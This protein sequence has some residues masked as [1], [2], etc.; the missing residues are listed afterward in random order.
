[1]PPPP[2][3]QTVAKITVTPGYMLLQPGGSA[4]L[5]ARAVDATGAVV[6]NAAITWSTSGNAVTVSADGT[7]SAGQSIDSAM[8]TA[9]VGSI[10]SAPVTVLVA[11]LNPGTQ[12]VDDSQVVSDPALLDANQPAGIGAQIKFTLAGST[13][14]AIGTLIVG[15]GAKPIDGKVISTAQNGANTDVVFQVMPL[16]DVFSELKLNQ[17]YAKDS[18]TQNFDVQPSQTIARTDGAREYEFILDT[19]DP[20]V[21]SAAAPAA[22]AKPRIKAAARPADALGSV[23]WSVGPFKCTAKS[24]LSAAISFKNMTP[25]VVDNLGPVSATI[26]VGQGVFSAQLSAKGS[27]T[28]SVDGEVHLSDAL[29]DSVSCDARLFEY[30]VPVPPVLAVVFIPVVPVIGLRANVSGTLTVGDVIIGVKSQVQQPLTVGMSIGTDGTFTNTSSLDGDATASFDWTLGSTN[31]TDVLRFSGDAK[32]GVFVQASFTSVLFALYKVFHP[33]FD[34]IKSLIDG[35]GGFH[36]TLGLAAVN[37]QLQDTTVA[38]GYAFTSLAQIQAGD[39]ISSFVSLL[40]SLLRLGNIV[41]PD[42]K[43]ETTL[44]SHPTG[45]ARVSLRRFAAGESV[46][47]RVVLDPTT[48]DPMFLGSPIIPYNVKQVQIWRKTAGGQ[49][50]MVGMDVGEAGA[51]GAPG[52]NVFNILW[53]ADAAGTTADTTS[54]TLPANFYAVVVPILG[55]DFSFRVGPALGWYGI[56]QIGGPHNGEGHRVAVDGDGN[57]IVATISGDPLASENRT[58]IG[59]AYEIEVFK[60]DPYGEL[61]WARNIDGPGDENVTGLAL[62]AQGNVF[63][64]GRAVNSPL[65]ANNIG[66]NGF[67]GWAASF[68]SSGNQLWLKQWQDGY[69]STGEFIALG[70]NREVYVL[71]TNSQAAGNVGGDVL[72]YLCNDGETPTGSGEDCGDLNLRR[73]DPNTGGLIWAISDARAGWQ[74]ARGLTVDAGG[75]IYTATGTGVD[76]ETQNTGDSSANGFER[77]RRWLSRAFGC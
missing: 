60:F 52:K 38:E 55:E 5:V 50:E 48:V 11:S 14:P 58:S 63:V 18:L 51:G 54:G 39:S 64:A 68:S 19:P 75:N 10:V 47:F 43:F 76:T 20:P 9:S 56:L 4:Q 30:F 27:I 33:D 42:L 16:A 12:V 32:A 67:S 13:A 29:K 65:T 7:I 34:P 28:L 22:R 62:D 44:F 6:S 25:H 46:A 77:L 2:P 36:G 49:S 73:L 61:I 71:G 15:S 40:S 26:N 45:N 1:M 74:I 21:P 66:A 3:A 41:L 59:G 57:L 72:N 37:V 69:Y 23:S 53:K 31:L 17:T 70:P 8:V 35:F 24:D